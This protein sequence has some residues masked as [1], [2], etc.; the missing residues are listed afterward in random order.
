MCRCVSLR[1]AACVAVDGG[2]GGDR[3]G[4]SDGAGVLVCPE[5]VTNKEISTLKT[6]S[7][8]VNDNT[9]MNCAIGPLPIILRQRIKYLV[10]SA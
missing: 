10:Q 6:V 5:D 9:E 1:V 7:M 3:G 4:G 2:G 8:F